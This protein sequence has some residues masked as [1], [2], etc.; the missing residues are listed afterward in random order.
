MGPVP[1]L[2]L[3]IWVRDPH[4]AKYPPFNS[5]HQRGITVTN[6][7]V[8]Q[9]MQHPVHNQM[10]DVIAQ[11]F[12]RGLGLPQAGFIQYKFNAKQLLS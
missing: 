5:F 8:T 12:A 3:D 9:K 2:I 4:L 11:R 10:G 6:V 1:G 7:I